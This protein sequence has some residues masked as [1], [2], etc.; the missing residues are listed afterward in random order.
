MK[1]KF[2]TEEILKNMTLEEKAAIVAGTD[3]MFTNPI[4][5]VNVPAL[6]MADGPHGLRKQTGSMDNGMAGSEPSTAF[7]TAAA[8]A[9]GWN[10]ENAKKTGEAIAEECAFYGVDILLGPGVNIKRN[11]LCGRNFE[12]YSEDPYL[13]GELAAG[14]IEGVQSKGIGTALK[15]F[16]LNNAEN[17]R[18]TGGS[19]ADMRA[20]REIYLRAFERAVK[21]GKPYTVMCAYNKINGVPCAENKWLLT[22]LLRGEWGFDGA[23]MTDWGAMRDRVDAV[24]AGLDLEMPGDTVYCR[25]SIINGVKNGGLEMSA[26]DRCVRNMLDLIA[27]CR[28]NE[29]VERRGKVDFEAHHALAAEIAED[30]AVLMKNDGALP[31]SNGEN[32]VIVGDLFEKMRYQGAGSSMINP[33]RVTSPKDAFDSRGVNYK[34]ARGYAVNKLVSDPE[35]I[36]A[37]VRLADGADKVLVFAGLTDYVEFEAGDRE[38]LSLPQNQ[39]DLINALIGAGKKI[40]VVLFGGAVVELPFADKVSAI[41]NMYLPGQNGG[42][43]VANLLFGDK[44]P[45]GKIAESW[46]KSY[47]D[48]PFGGEF[49]KTANEVYKESVFVGYRYYL[50]AQKQVAFPFGFGLSYTKFGYSDMAVE[51]CGED[52]CVSCKVMNTGLRFGAEIVQLYVQAPNGGVFKPL[53]ELRAFTKI[54]LKAGESGRAEMTFA[55]ADLKYWNIAENRFVAEGGNY[56]LQICSD[57]R[58]VK[59]EKSVFI[60]GETV[61]LPY[62][63]QINEVYSGCNFDNVTLETFENMSGVKV[64]VLPA[65]K[66]IT[67]ESRFSDLKNTFFGKILYAAVMSVPRREL[68]R[69]KKLPDGVERENRIKGAIFLEKILNS[70]CLRSMS[71]SSPM[72]PYNAAEGVKELSNGHIL[73][74]IAKFC[75]KIRVTKLP[76]NKK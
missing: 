27:K 25:K 16:A 44:N 7:P 61:G 53:R 8:V 1:R 37:A 59:L 48:V 52:I 56:A 6:S 18:F 30:C 35:T 12:Y 45:C 70:G 74:A 2:N 34:F 23:V 17:F 67:M 32:L 19:F 46:V 20:M 42:T 28:G 13:A 47:A 9:C 51:E 31:L 69:V 24:N 49:S 22:D 55:K 58:T 64:P 62:Q 43:A 68:K 65:V 50:T 40:I 75:K 11:P 38:N 66:P 39:L 73:R 4:P 26:L 3:F 63:I 21:K 29:S 71:M 33:Y 10:I 57:C 15:H 76:K 36:T 5:R 54:Y 72:L 41:L 14:E 60:G